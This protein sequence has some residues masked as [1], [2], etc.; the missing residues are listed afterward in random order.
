MIDTK[1]IKYY[2]IHNLDINRKNIMLNEFNK[3]GFET[4]KPFAHYKEDINSI[5]LTKI[6]GNT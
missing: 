1:I 3:C 4:S 2:L 5:Y 6:I